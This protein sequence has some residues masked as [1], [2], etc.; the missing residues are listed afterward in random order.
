MEDYKKALVTALQHDFPNELVNYI[1]LQT[2]NFNGFDINQLWPQMY[3]YNNK[4]DLSKFIQLGADVNHRMADSESWNEQVA[5]DTG[6]T[7][8]MYAAQEGLVTA[9]IVLLENNAD[10]SITNDSGNDVFYFA[11]ASVVDLIKKYQTEKENSEL[12]KKNQMLEQQCQNMNDKINYLMNMFE[13]LDV[14]GLALGHKKSKQ[15]IE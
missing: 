5:P 6:S 12:L 8:I 9:V 2:C 11:K 1:Y 14:E 3:H 7:P 15:V 10:I 4:K 13:R